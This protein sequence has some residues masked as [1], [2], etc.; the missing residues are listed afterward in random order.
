MRNNQSNTGIYPATSLLRRVIIIFLSFALILCICFSILYSVHNI[1]LLKYFMYVCTI[2]HILWLVGFLY[3]KQ[4]SNESL[5]MMYIAYIVAILYPFTCIHWNAGNPVEFC[6]YL[7]VLFGVIVFQMRS[8]GVWISGILFIVSSVFFCSRFFP[9]VDLTPALIYRENLLIVISTITLSAFFAVV[10]VKK[11]IFYEP[12]PVETIDTPESAENIEKDKALYAKIISYIENNEP[13]KNPDFNAHLL[14]MAINS[15]TAYV[16]KAI[17]T[18]GN[19]NFK[20]LLNHFR[21]KYVKS[22]L[23]NGA[24]K[25]YT[26]DYIYAEAGYKHRSTFNAAF[27]SIIGMTPSEY[28]SQQNANNNLLQ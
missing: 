14:A 7:L 11:I 15:N 5:I 24:L 8:I 13:F 1:D 21:I 12:A 25:K 17:N 27:K 19:D 23:D 3:Y 20:T 28:A 26:I 22:L 18:N 10:Y 4:M 2:Q 6:W 16:S 9:K